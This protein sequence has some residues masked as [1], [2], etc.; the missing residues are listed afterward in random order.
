MPMLTCL[1]EVI[2]INPNMCI[3]FLILPHTTYQLTVRCLMCT[4]A[5]HVLSLSLS[6]CGSS[7]KSTPPPTDEDA[8]S[9]QG[10][11]KGEDAHA[12]YVKLPCRV[13]CMFGF[14]VRE[15]GKKKVNSLWYW[16][17]AHRRV[18][19]A[20]RSWCRC[21]MRTS[22]FGSSPISCKSR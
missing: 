17:C 20:R 2:Q 11:V 15:S 4:H 13:K 12:F 14:C 8:L 21:D 18:L 10:K 19:T 6:K 9:G 7:T 5:S 16:F 22:P 1:D 3:V